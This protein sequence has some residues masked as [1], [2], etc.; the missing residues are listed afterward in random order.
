MYILTQNGS[1]FQVTTTVKT[2]KYSAKK[3]CMN[4][5]CYEF[6]EVRG[7]RPQKF[8]NSYVQKSK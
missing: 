8:P 6:D 7:K 5:I 1:F 4:Q 2:T 3:A